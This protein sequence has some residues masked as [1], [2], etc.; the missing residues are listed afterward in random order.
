VAGEMEKDIV[1]HK[2][3]DLKLTQQQTDTSVRETQK[4]IATLEKQLSSTPS[5]M[6]TAVRTSDNGQLMMQLKSTLLTLELKRT[7]LL[8]KFAPSY[9]AVREVD[10]EIANTNA[11]IASA[12]RAP[13]L[14]KTT[15]RD[16]TYEW[17]RSEL[18]RSH[19]E[20]S[21]LTSRSISLAKSNP[22]ST[23]NVTAATGL[24]SR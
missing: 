13:L 12:E 1:V 23:T 10:Q 17:I 20:L 24:F 3:G 6:E 7:D 21:A 8:Q 4:R 5:R 2:L 18:A 16:P 19:A 11:A 9:R 15:D 14:D 22:S